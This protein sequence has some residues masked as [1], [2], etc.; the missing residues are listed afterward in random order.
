MNKCEILQSKLMFFFL[1]VILLIIINGSCISPE[2]LLEDTTLCV[3]KEQYPNYYVD[4][5]NILKKC[6]YPCYECSKASDEINQNCLSCERGYQF[7]SITNNCIKCPKNK[8]KYIY[9]SYDTCIDSNEKYCKKEITKCTLLT[10]DLFKGCPLELPILIESKKMCV[11][12]NICDSSD[13]LNG[14]CTFSYVPYIKSRTINPKNFLKNEELK[15]KHNLGVFTDDYGNLLF[16]AC[17]DSDKQRFFYGIKKNGKANFTDEENKPNYVSFNISDNMVEY[18]NNNSFFLLDYY[19][20]YGGNYLIAFSKNYFELYGF[21]LSAINTERIK[22]F[23]LNDLLVGNKPK[24]ENYQISSS[25]NTFLKYKVSANQ[26]NN[27]YILSFVA[28]NESNEYSLYIWITSLFSL[29]ILVISDLKMYQFN[30]IDNYK[31]TSLCITDSYNIFFLYLNIE[32]DLKITFIKNAYSVI[33][34]EEFLINNNTYLISNTINKNH[35]FSCL[36]LFEETVIILYFKESKLFLSIK[37]VVS[38]DSLINYNDDFNNVVINDGQN[39]K[40][41]PFYS[42]TEAIKINLKKFVIFSKFENN[43]KVLIM[44]CEL[45]NKE[46]NIYKSMNVRYYELSLIDNDIEFDNF[47][48]YLFNGLFGIYYYNK[49]TFFP[50]FYYLVI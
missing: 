39:Y 13:F 9:S 29:E 33:K 35:Y 34:T 14:I 7:D 30:S 22:Q 36:F 50:F 24:I 20:F 21:E 6:D 18:I 11:S 17:G 43:E 3:E 23:I 42:D 32:H 41:S 16:E 8:Y 27:V 38:D 46:D 2:Y 40:I 49:I 45:Y 26:L 19:S 48:L 44:L 31:R 25:I 12:K 28:V 5:D 1:F 10:Y 4:N 37:T 47:Y 15:D